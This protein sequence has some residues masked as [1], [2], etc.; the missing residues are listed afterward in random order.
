MAYVLAGGRGS[1]LLE[2][3][4][5]RAK[6]AV[7]F[8]GK[9]RIIDFALSTA[10]TSGIRR[11]GVAPQY[12]A[13]SLIRHLQRGWNFF[14]P[15]RNESFDI[16]PASQRVAD[17]KWYMGTADAVYQHIDIIESYAPHYI[18]LL[19]GDHVYKMDYE[20]MLQ[21]HVEQGADV[22]VGCIE[23]SREE[24]TGFGVMGIDMQD[25]IISF[26]EKPIDPPSM[27]GRPGRSLASMGIY[28][29]ETKFLID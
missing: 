11:I 7:Y 1:R 28:V 9:S 4:D 2:L 27:P 15:E 17:D 13:H 22:T 25:Q 26:L 29:F 8:G 14:R 19:A 21:Q 24:A 10:L 16:L 20:L 18:V 3:T 6:P 5:M 23:V 12:K